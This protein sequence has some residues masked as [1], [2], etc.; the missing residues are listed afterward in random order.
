M[1]GKQSLNTSTKKLVIGL[2]IG[3]WTQ[4]SLVDTKLVNECDTVSRRNISHWTQ[5]SSVDVKLITGFDTRHNT[6]NWT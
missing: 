6:G 4:N 3:Q 2:K 5:N 1:Q